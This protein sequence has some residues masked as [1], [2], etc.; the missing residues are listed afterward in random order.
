MA[1]LGVRE[2]EVSRG[3]LEKERKPG[4]RTRRDLEMLTLASSHR[5]SSRMQ[6]ADDEGPSCCNPTSWSSMPPPSCRRAPAAPPPTRHRGRPVAARGAELVDAPPILLLLLHELLRGKGEVMAR[7]GRGR[8]EAATAGAREKRRDL[9]EESGGRRRG[10]RR[11]P[12]ERRRGKER[13][14]VG[15]AARIF[16]SRVSSRVFTELASM[17]TARGRHPSLVSATPL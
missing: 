15:E 17:H 5:P 12:V 2:E 7:S 1:G 13:E 14:R 9:V 6:E 11:R 4:R 10:L 8:E 16:S 3:D